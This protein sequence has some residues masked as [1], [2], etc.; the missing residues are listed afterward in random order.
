[1]YSR[2]IDEQV[3]TLSASGWTY[4][5]TFVL[6]DYETETMWLPVDVGEAGIG[7]GCALWGIAGQYAGRILP[8]LPSEN[9]DWPEWFSDHPDTRI[10]TTGKTVSPEAPDGCHE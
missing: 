9:T 7:C 6:F 3:L 10:M 8:A 4:E 1:M 2:E 5:F